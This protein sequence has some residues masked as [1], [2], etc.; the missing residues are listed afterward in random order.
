[1]LY[2]LLICLAPTGPTQTCAPSEWHA[3]P[4]AYQ[5]REF[6]EADARVAAEWG[7]SA[8]KCVEDK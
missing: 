5:Q 8:G 1:M 2:V 7:M 4:N 6:C 3:L